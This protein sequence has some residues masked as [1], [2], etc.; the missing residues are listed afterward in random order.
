MTKGMKKRLKGVQN[1]LQFQLVMNWAAKGIAVGALLSVLLLILSKFAPLGLDIIR[2]SV[3][4]LIAGF[5]IGA[6]AA[7]LRPIKLFDAAFACDIHLGLKERLTSAIE[8]SDQKD[9]N[10]LIPALIEDADRHSEKINPPRDFP[11]RYPREILYAFILVA[12]ATGLYFVPPWQYV[13]A[14]EE[15]KDEYEVVI[16]EAERVRELAQEI[17]LDLPTERSEVAEEIAR[18]L[19]ELARDMEFGTLTRR[20]ALERL[21]AIEEAINQSQEESGYND[22]REQ[23][24]ELAEALANSSDLGDAA[25]AMAEGDASKIQEALDRLASDLEQGRIPMENLSDLA[26]A[27]DK[28]IAQMGNDPAMADAREALAQA[29][30]ELRSAAQSGSMGDQEQPSPEEMA[31]NL[32]DAID[33]AIPEIQNLEDVPQDVKDQAEQMLE[34]IRDELQEALDSGEVTQQDINEA[35]RGIQE[36]KRMLEDAGADFSGE[37]DNRSQEEIAQEL[38][39]EAERLEREAGKCDALDAQTQSELQ[40]LC[41]N[42]AQSLQNDISQNS[43]S[44]QS[45][46]DAREKLDEVRKQLGENDV[47]EEQMGKRS[48]CSGGQCQSGQQSGQQGNQSNS[49]LNSLFGQQSNS[50][51]GQ[52]GQQGQQGEA[53]QCCNRAG[54]CM[55]QAGQ[56]MSDKFGECLGSGS[57]FNKMNQRISQCRGGLC[58]GSGSNPGQESGG[59]GVGQRAGGGWGTG[60]TPYATGPSPVQPGH[61]NQDWNDPNQTPNET[62]DYQALYKPSIEQSQTYDV[63][64]EGKFTDVGGSYIFTEVVDPDTGETSYVPYFSLEPTDVETLMDAVEDQDIPRS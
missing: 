40:S 55:R 7:L 23:L 60:S 48:Q 46:R 21:S 13:F 20:E 37:E 12:I 18:E 2:T 62:R 51:Q 30:D 43:C 24:A 27:L 63:Q 25:D 38:I 1:Q 28:A 47:S 31:E 57:K 9:T 64:L 15:E 34:N 16:A 41:Q 8:F 14:S 59:Q 50:G 52:Q 36:V 17:T 6:I 42:V 49:G 54:Q 58:S 33:R 53:G 56:C 19:Q 44:D 61:Q 3:S 39:E 5:V 4:L 26:D 45:N 35:Q 11:I 32:I 29:R 10:P 22:L